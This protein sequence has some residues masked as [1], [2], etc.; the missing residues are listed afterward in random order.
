MIFKVTDPIKKNIS[1]RKRSTS[2]KSY[3]FLKP[4]FFSKIKKH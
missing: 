2:I 3:V 1:L 4:S